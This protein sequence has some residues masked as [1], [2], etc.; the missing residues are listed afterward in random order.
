MGKYSDMLQQAPAKPA[1][2]YSAMVHEQ[3][4]PA[5]DEYSPVNDMGAA[6]R[7]R[8]GIGVGGML[9]AGLLKNALNDATLWANENIPG[10]RRLDELGQRIGLD[11]AQNVKARNDAGRAEF[12]RTI[13]PLESTT[14]GKVGSVIGTAG[15]AVPT[16]LIP[17]AGTYTGA[18]L[19]GAGTGAALS[20]TGERGAGAAVGAV[21]GVVGKGVADT[22]AKGVG[23]AV[24]KLRS[25]S[26]TANPAAA[27][28]IID[29]AM[30]EAG[31]N[32]SMLPEA[33]RTSLREEVRKAVQSG[34]TV[35]MAALQRKADFL[36]LGAKPTLG[37]ITRD[38][39]QFAKEKTLMGV[40]GAG[41]ELADIATDNNRL[42]ID[43][44]NRAGAAQAP[45]SYQAG[46]ALA[47][48]LG[49]Y[50]EQQQGAINA[51]YQ[52]ARNS[53]G[54]AADL[55]PAF[56]ANRA[57]DLLE[58]NLKGAFLPGEIRSTLN[59][60]AQGKIPFNVNVAEQ[61]KTVLA[62]AQRSSQDGNVRAAVGL[63]RDALE[64]TPLLAAPRGPIP[65]NALPSNLPAGPE[66]NPL[67]REAV[68]A[69]TKARAATRAF[70]QQIESTPALRDALDGMEPDKFFQKHVLSANV[71]DLRKTVNVLKMSAPDA[72]QPIRAQVLDHLKQKA[73]NGA[74]DEVGNFSQAGYN[75]ALNSL[76]E[77]RLKALFTPQELAQ[78][79]LIG[80][81]ASYAQVAPAGSVVNR[82]GTAA[83]AYNLLSGLLEKAQKI[84]FGKAAIV[85][86]AQNIM[87][88]MAAKNAMRAAV[89][90]AP[91]PDPLQSN[92]LIQLL[93]KAGPGAFGTG[94]D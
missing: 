13:A 35:D 3:N 14:A 46:Q 4:A 56:F 11:S 92:A 90:V 80:R 42:F 9:G 73:L 62:T 71:A 36:A 89:P 39:M 47:G 34:G 79:K 68:E 43:T 49:K 2:K 53:E 21:A 63:V 93:K 78:L 69:F 22:L 64:D 17:G 50:G 31:L 41:R 76:G 65:P 27:Q 57:N 40:E 12:R 88:G 85:D 66:A 33:A 7:L 55:D 58:H 16:A 25:L 44:L 59:G 20:E 87:G 24:Q 5:I 54:R 52:A 60:I 86:P 38:P 15:V 51:L 29:D 77:E 61:L 67:G 83:Q 18:A 30:R 23:L 32:I 75:K 48:S 84:P 45:G 10:M 28:Q 72:L 1:S 8:A 37:T 70:K 91:A 94:A 19:I 82:S 6:E 81:V 26:A 74:A